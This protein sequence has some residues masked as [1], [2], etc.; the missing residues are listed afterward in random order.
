MPELVV[1]SHEQ[2][3]AMADHGQVL[4][5]VILNEPLPAVLETVVLDEDRVY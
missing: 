5:V 3:D 4:P 2:P 1:V